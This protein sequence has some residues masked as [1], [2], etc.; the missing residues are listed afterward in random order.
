MRASTVGGIWNHAVKVRVMRQHFN[1]AVH[2]LCPYE[3][4]QMAEILFCHNEHKNHDA[5][6]HEYPYLPKIRKLGEAHIAY[7]SDMLGIGAN[8]KKLQ[9]QMFDKNWK[10][11]IMKDLSNIQSSSKKIYLNSRNDPETVC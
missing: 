4:P 9:Q 2:L 7:I 10:R 3:Y 5:Y 1:A 11:V 8:K 6:E